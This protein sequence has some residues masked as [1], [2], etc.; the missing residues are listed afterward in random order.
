MTFIIPPF[1]VLWGA[2]F[3]G[4]PLDWAYAYGG[5]LIGVALWLIL[6]PAPAPTVAPETQRS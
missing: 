2:L 6:K 3:L 1:G 4:E 5:A